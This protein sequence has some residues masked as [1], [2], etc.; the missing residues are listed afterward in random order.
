MV[1]RQILTFKVL[2]QVHAVSPGVVAEVALARTTDQ[3]HREQVPVEVVHV[4]AATPRTMVI[5]HIQDTQNIGEKMI[6]KEGLVTKVKAVE[7]VNVNGA[8]RT[9]VAL[10]DLEAAH[11]EDTNTD[12]VH[13]GI[14]ERVNQGQGLGQEIDHIK[15]LKETQGEDEAEVG[16]IPKMGGEGGDPRQ[17]FA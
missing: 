16:V 14:V 4:L 9:H 8:A 1:A 15:C 2:H 12:T 11:L 10:R 17:K 5:I 7:C 3:D 6:T 13:T